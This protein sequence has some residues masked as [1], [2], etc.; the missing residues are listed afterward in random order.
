MLAA[1]VV[2]ARYF[3][4]HLTAENMDHDEWF[5]AEPILIHHY[6][7]GEVAPANRHAQA[8]VIWTDE[9]LCLRFDC[10]QE[11]PL[12]VHPSPQK[13]TK[14]IGLWERDVSELF[15][16]P[17]ANQPEHYYEFEAA[18]TG[19]W[20]DLAIKMTGE[21]RTTDWNYQSGMKTAARMASKRTVIAMCIPW[22]NS[23]PKPSPGDEWRGNLCRCVGDGPNRGYLAWQPTYAEVPNFHVPSAFG[24]ICFVE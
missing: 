17:N 21:V 4:T 12:I 22:S 6:W 24:R 1:D 19:E 15:L 18:P 23:I 10:R 2:E 16:A 8:R 7:S 13:E 20:L 3:N 11:E 5:Q 14:T 9:A